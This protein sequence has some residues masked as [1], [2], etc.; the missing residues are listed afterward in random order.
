MYRCVDMTMG[1]RVGRNSQIYS[2]NGG[3]PCAGAL[4]EVE[5]CNLESPDCA[6]DPV[7]CVLSEWSYWSECSADCGS[8]VTKRTRTVGSEGFVGVVV[9]TKMFCGKNFWVFDGYNKK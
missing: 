2:S 7:D 9:V 8:G 6:G 3:K 5:G 4:K 1:V